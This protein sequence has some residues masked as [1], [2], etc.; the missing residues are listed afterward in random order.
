MALPAVRAH[1]GADRRYAWLGPAML[2]TTLRGE[3]GGADPLSGFYFREA[4]HLSRLS[5][6]LDGEPPWL[7]AEG[8][9]SNDGLSL[10]YSWPEVTS[11]GGGGSD[12]SDDTIVRNAG[13]VPQRA[14]EMR[15]QHQVALTGMEATL[16]VVN[17]GG[18][19][20]RV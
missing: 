2:V 8:Q 19:R 20:V 18:E 1:V 7:C 15:L 6:Q 10:V 14:L 12:A 17:R 16:V 5:L 3:C 13:G 4:R 11:F 9:S